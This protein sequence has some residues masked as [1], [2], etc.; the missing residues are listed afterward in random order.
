MHEIAEQF[1]FRMG[2]AS[3]FLS[4]AAAIAWGLLRVL[5]CQSPFVHRTVWS[6]VLAQ[7]LL[8]MQIPVAIPWK[9]EVH[10]QRVV[11]QADDAP[12]KTNSKSVAFQPSTT[13]D[14][15][16]AETPHGI[17]NWKIFSILCLAWSI[18]VLWVL[19]QWIVR[20][21]WFV[22]HLPSRK[23]DEA[24][25]SQEW[26]EL[27]RER[28]LGAR[29]PIYLSENVGPM[30]C[31]WPNGQRVVVPESL[32]SRLPREQ[33]LVILRHELAHFERHDLLKILIANLIAA[34]HWFNPLAWFAVRRFEDSI[35]W[36]CDH[37]VQ[38]SKPDAKVHYAK[39][40]LALGNLGAH[41]PLPTTWAS[42]VFGGGL[43]GRIRRVVSL[44]S[45]HDSLSKILIALGFLIGLSVIHV[46]RVELVAK[47]ENALSKNIISTDYFIAPVLTDLQKW[48]LRGIGR[49][50]N[51]A[52]SVYA[53]INCRSFLNKQKPTLDL[54]R[55]DFD[56]F[57]RDLVRVQS[58]A[59][60]GITAVCL[61]FEN[62]ADQEVMTDA[63]ADKVEAAFR[64]RMKVAGIENVKFIKRFV[65]D[66]SGWRNLAA[67]IGSKPKESR[68][69]NANV[70][71][72]PVESALSRF[73]VSQSSSAKARAVDCFIDIATIQPGQAKAALTAEDEQAIRASIAELDM[74][75]GSTAL[76]TVHFAKPQDWSK[77]QEQ[78]PQTKTDS[79]FQRD[80][81]Q[82]LK[83]LGFGQ[84]RIHADVNGGAMFTSLHD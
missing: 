78:F 60:D 2:L 43:A 66:G 55:F 56:A 40:L 52:V 14:S 62:I 42:A 7:S 82:F 57:I 48:E 69:G 5:S 54:N 1:V 21:V 67:E 20:Y 4:S 71:I 76:L 47:E 63:V 64:P 29:I 26:E 38:A 11:G 77:V 73:L 49:S 72:F 19:G 18:G 58:G 24:L 79:A 33:R 70:S 51:K 28:G 74:P 31:R 68:L 53:N 84:V 22:R 59:T 8:V 12:E 30:L 46:V 44:D 61:D 80:V 27:L 23:C 34:A 41:S 83:S 6:L 39:A 45:A 25:W 17:F 50:A 65:N 37:I 10:S 9:P 35:E 36:T 3:A 13:T 15:R 75:K 81:A 16:S 32:W